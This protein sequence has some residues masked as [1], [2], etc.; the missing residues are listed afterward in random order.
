[1]EKIRI[2]TVP[3]P[4]PVGIVGFTVNTKALY[5]LASYCGIL[6]LNPPTIYISLENDSETSSRILKNG[7][8]SFNMPSVD[9]FKKISL[10]K[11]DLC[12]LDILDNYEAF[13]DADSGSP[14]L[15]DAPLNLSCRVTQTLTM[16]HTIVIIGKILNTYVRESCL[17]E[18]TRNPHLNALDPVVSFSDTSF[19]TSGTCIA[20]AFSIGNCY[21]NGL[22]GSC[23]HF[24][25]SFAKSSA[26]KI[27]GALTFSKKILSG[28]KTFGKMNTPIGP[29]ALLYPLPTVLL[30]S[31]VENKP[32]YST[33]GN[34][35]ILSL[36]PM[37]MY[38]SSVKHHYTN[39]GIK[40]NKTFSINI[41]GPK[42]IQQ[43]D[44]CG[45][46]SG[47]RGDKTKIF[48]SFYGENGS[49]PM[50][51]ECPVNIECTVANILTINA[52]E[53]CIG[54]VD[55]VYLDAGCLQEGL[56]DIKKINPVLYSL[57]R[58]YW[59]IGEPV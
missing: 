21:G 24:F 42:I 38:V 17:I 10:H 35:G 4:L 50:I 56:P 40:A 49:A 15:K 28:E 41:P 23:K 37:T 31:A 6:C 7:F 20:K 58:T 51:E 22:A 44:Y 55:G 2:T 1:M 33:I 27:L 26:L 30:G 18:G 3:I 43:T 46:V 54:T 47:S 36:D 52:M 5:A 29:R 59:T 9:L 19:W 11:K 13:H 12:R 53:I 8:F 25:K 16:N 34:C 48:H 32:N 14:M 57:D 39:K 45:L